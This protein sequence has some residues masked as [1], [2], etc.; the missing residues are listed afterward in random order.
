MRSTFKVLFYLKK[1]RLTADGYPVMCR[2]TVNGTQTAFSCKMTVPA[3]CWDMAANRPKKSKSPRIIEINDYLDDIENRLKKHYRLLCEKTDYVTA[4]RVK[5][6][7]HGFGDDNKT[8]LEAYDYRLQQ[9]QQDIGIGHKQSTYD[10]LSNERRCLE[11]FLKDKYREDMLLKE[12]D[13]EFIETYYQWMLGVRGYNATTAFGRIQSLKCVL[14][15]AVAKHWVS[16]HP[17]LEFHCRPA[18]AER[19]RLTDDEICRLMALDLRYHRQRAIRDMFIFCCFTGLAYADLRNLRYRDIIVNEAGVPCIYAKREKTG[20]EYRIQLLPSPLQLIEQYRGYPGKLSEDR[21]FPVKDRNSMI[22]TLKKLAARAGIDKNLSTH[23]GRHTFATTLT[24]AKDVPLKTVSV[25]LGH[26]HITT[27][28]IY[29]KITASKMK[30]DMSRLEE[31]LSD[32]F[33]LQQEAQPPKP[34]KSYYVKKGA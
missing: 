28:E 5:D 8:L 18:P 16:H 17:F 34:Y 13:S 31:H 25:M 27:T 29:A 15:I 21:I 30:N 32:T 6:A 22:T 2:I 26:K 14:Y 4:Q 11:S 10:K 3:E 20:T 33:T 7:Y 23:V 1:S 24:L 19:T 9:V 12:L